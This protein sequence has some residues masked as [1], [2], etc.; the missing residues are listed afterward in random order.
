MN[1]RDKTDIRAEDFVFRS[2]RINSLV[3]K[4]SAVFIIIV[5]IMNMSRVL[6]FTND[7]RLSTLN[8]RIY[9]SFYLTY[10][11][12]AVCFLVVDRKLSTA[13]MKRNRFHMVCIGVSVI[14][15]LLFNMY[16]IYRAG[17]AGNFTITV[18]VFFLTGLF[19][20]RPV[21]VLSCL[22]VITAVFSPYLYSSY[23]SGEAINFTLT[24]IICGLIYY[25]RYRSIC[26]EIAQNREIENARTE[27]DNIKEEFSLNL[28]QYRIINRSENIITFE[29]KTDTDVISFSSEWG[30]YFE[31]DSSDMKLSYI[32]EE[33]LEVPEETKSVIRKS[34]EGIKKGVPYQIY[35][36]DIR[37]RNGE[38][39]NFIIRIV[40]QKNQKGEPVAGVG[41][42]TDM[43]GE[44]N[45]IS[46]LEKKLDIDG[47]TGLLN[48]SAIEKYGR[49]TLDGLKEDE[50]LAALIIDM[51][52][53]K[54]INDRYGHLTGDHVLKRISDILSETAPEGAKVG[55][56]GGDEFIALGV[57]EST[58]EFRKY[59]ER[60][61]RALD[62]VK[63]DGNI[64]NLK[65]SIGIATA[66]RKEKYND[67]YEKT[68]KAMYHAKQSGKG[69]Y[70]IAQKYETE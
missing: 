31:R 10:F 39:R 24:V 41:T 29:W 40:T 17:A 62:T 53:F 26:R 13:D 42:I 18:M 48:K 69:R 52:D 19:M 44:K 15:H 38:T 11:V 68:D 12:L 50:N 66:G 56:I 55:R 36:C 23:S 37:D 49:K 45:Q 16:D 60:I 6:F 22:A 33:S 21:Y 2:L 7:V 28:E 51:D 4:A 70:Y 9:F 63:I 54:Y 35:E 5:E 67:L 27:I 1:F 64:M 8:N 65:C 59:A 3:L 20:M 25:M 30:N 32:L 47:F 34:V 46:I 57:C 43:T 58:E 14:W 61:M